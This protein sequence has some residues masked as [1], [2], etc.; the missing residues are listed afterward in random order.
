MLIDSDTGRA[1]LTTSQAR[2]RSGLSGVYLAQLLRKSILE[3]FKIDR[4]WF[5]Y[6][7][8]LESFLA[9]E[10]KSGPHGPRK[11]TVESL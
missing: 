9:K 5:I 8:S 11:K 7:D 2:E 4:E 1:C 10:R 3:G 6:S